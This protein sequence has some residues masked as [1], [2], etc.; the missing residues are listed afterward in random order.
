MGEIPGK[1]RWIIA[2]NKTNVS[3]FSS[4]LYYVWGTLVIMQIFDFRFLDL[5]VLGSGKSKNQ[6]ISM[7]S[8]VHLLVSMLVTLL[9]CGDNIF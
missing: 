1:R 8:G 5:H 4:P 2:T 3:P 6:K 7:M 9:I